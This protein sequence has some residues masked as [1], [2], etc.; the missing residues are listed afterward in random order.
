MKFFYRTSIPVFVSGQ[1][2]FYMSL[3]AV[4]MQLFVRLTLLM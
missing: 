3:F 4:I 2:L 1:R